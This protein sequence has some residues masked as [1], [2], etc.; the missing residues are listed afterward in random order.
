[1]QIG[2][3]SKSWCRLLTVAG[4]FA[5][6]PSTL[7]WEWN[8]HPECEGEDPVTGECDSPSVW[9]W[10]HDGVEDPIYERT[11]QVGVAENQSTSLGS[12][13]IAYV[14]IPSSAIP[15]YTFAVKTNIGSVVSEVEDYTNTSTVYYSIISTPSLSVLPSGEAYIA[16]AELRSTSTSQL[17]T[18]RK[19]SY[20]GTGWDQEAAIWY[21]PE[22]HAYRYG[23]GAFDVQIYDLDHWVFGGNY[24]S[25]AN[26]TA[27]YVYNYRFKMNDGHGAKNCGTTPTYA[28]SFD[29]TYDEPDLQGPVPFSY[30]VGN[31][32][33]SP[34]TVVYNA[35]TSYGSTT[36]TPTGQQLKA[37]YASTSSPYN[38][39]YD[40]TISTIPLSYFAL[41]TTNA[42]KRHV[43][44]QDTVTPNW[45][46]LYCATS[47]AVGTWSTHQPYATQ[48]WYYETIYGEPIA[49]SADPTAS[50][51]AFDVYL[52]TPAYY[53]PNIASVLHHSSGTSYTVDSVITDTS[54]TLLRPGSKS[55]GTDGTGENVVSLY[56]SIHKSEIAINY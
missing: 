37:Y 36:G 34:S 13:A 30:K 54:S 46:W 32:S 28:R 43:V 40:A 53:D 31:S 27:N 10:C 26:S 17:I 45:N 52:W 3:D 11:E 12:P 22:M 18:I 15:T 55:I 25:Q 29:Y 42:N 16:F 24:W 19:Y 48:Y 56:N 47:S 38:V 14:A 20:D 1:M 2:R 33:S 4:I 50:S 6:A 51:D 8:C 5:I 9:Y 21:G 7:A 35:A 23:I 39:A 44:Y 41:V 49:A